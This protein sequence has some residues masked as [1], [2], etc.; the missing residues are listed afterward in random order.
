MFASTTKMQ[1][2]WDYGH[3]LQHTPFKLLWREVSVRT[4]EKVEGSTERPYLPS[5][6][7]RVIL[8]FLKLEVVL[9]LRTNPNFLSLNILIGCQNGDLYLCNRVYRIKSSKC[10]CCVKRWGHLRFS[11]LLPIWFSFFFLFKNSFFLW[12]CWVLVVALGAF[13]RHV[14]PFCG[15]A[16]G[17]QGSLQ[18]WCMGSVAP[19]HVGF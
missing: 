19:Q 18:L 13:V 10:N 3:W 7:G 12:L 17:V 16:A 2:L 8:H 11:L 9:F 1:Q 4:G 5:V 14:G 15:G 6:A